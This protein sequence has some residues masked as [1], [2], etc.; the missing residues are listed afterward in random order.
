M[1]NRAV[2]SERC[3]VL[4]LD[5]PAT[6]AQLGTAN[7]NDLIGEAFSTG[8]TWMTIPASCLGDAFFAL[9]TGVAGE[10]VQKF[11]N[12]RLHVGIIGDIS[13]YVATSKSLHD[14]VHE[15]N[16]GRQLWF[17]NTMEEFD[18]RLAAMRA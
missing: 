4:V 17:V 11:V 7:V 15:S 13:A 6:G 1:P 12:Y 8:A 18:E 10:L 16:R 9:H 14:F 2:A 3:G 5:Y